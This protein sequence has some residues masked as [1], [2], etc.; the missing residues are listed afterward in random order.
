MGLVVHRN[1]P[2]ALLTN[3]MYSVGDRLEA[4]PVD[5]YN[6]M[7]TFARDICILLPHTGRR[8]LAGV[9]KNR[10]IGDWF[11]RKVGEGRIR[12]S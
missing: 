3:L 8:H 1:N 10:Y 9:L 5:G 11:Y 7:I 6:D 2:W 4:Y 12:L